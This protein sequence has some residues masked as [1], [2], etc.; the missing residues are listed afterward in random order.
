MG[1]TYFFMNENGR[2]VGILKPCDEEPLAP[3][4]PKG[5]VG[6]ALGDPGWKPTVRVG[7]AAMREVGPGPSLPGGDLSLMQC[8]QCVL[9]QPTHSVDSFKKTAC[10]AVVVAHTQTQL[11]LSSVG[12]C[13]AVYFVV[14]RQALRRG[15]DL[16]GCTCPL[17][18]L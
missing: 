13:L 14:T 17:Q 4:N 8:R 7:E 9:P 12:G 3:N 5:Y 16:S 18:R 6:R 10:I 1:G 2:K 11:Q 15:P